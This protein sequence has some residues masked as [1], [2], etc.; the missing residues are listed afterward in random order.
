MD[1]SSFA[2][3]ICPDEWVRIEG[4]EEAMVLRLIKA[5]IC[6]IHRHLSLSLRRFHRYIKSIEKKLLVRHLRY[7][8][9]LSTLWYQ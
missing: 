8:F 9:E 7:Q 1:A 4:E 2:Q 5:G 3:P 6:S